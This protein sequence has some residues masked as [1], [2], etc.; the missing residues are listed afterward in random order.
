MNFKLIV[1]VIGML[2]LVEGLALLLSAFVAYLSGGDDFAALALSAGLSL[3]PGIFALLA[4]SLPSSSLARREAFFVVTVGWLIISFIGSLP[5]LISGYIPNITDAFFETMSGFTTTGATILDDI[6]ALP[7]G[8]LFWRAMTQWLGGMGIIVLALSFL[9]AFGI[10]GMQLYVAEAPGL[11]L[12][13]VSPRV[14]QTARTIWGLYLSL[15]LLEMVLLMLGGLSWFDSICH[16]FTTM[17]TG[18]FSTKQA[19]IAYWQSPYIQYV[20]TIFMIIAGTNFTLMF[21]ALTGKPGR[22]FR[23]EEYRFYIFFILGFTALIF[24]GLMLT[25]TGAVE[26]AFR[27]AL[28]TVVSVMT[29]TGFV[30]ADYLL[31][32]PVLIMLIFALFFF[33]ASIGSTGG[34]VKIMRIGVLLKNSYY[35]LQRLIHPHAVIPVR[36]NSV[37]LEPKFVNNILAFFMFYLGIF[38]V[39]SII[40]TIFEPDMVTSMGAVASCLANIGP[41]LGSV[42]PIFSYSHIPEVG[43]WFLSFLMMIGRLELFT[44]LILFTPAFWKK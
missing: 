33:G 19:S 12:D 41:G 44:V 38:F 21:F 17:A 16:S 22:L 34:G 36:F 29:T 18:G 10:G 32:P 27:D 23:H 40:M 24:A 13:K 31:W 5:Y 30:T 37:S 4:T 11:S 28:F 20:V 14:Y 39:S 43:K 3:A 6:E 35:E 1:R 15:T 42:G 9:P 25:G 2:L 7:R 26:A 8:L